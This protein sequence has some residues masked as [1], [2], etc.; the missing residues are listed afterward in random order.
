MLMY[1]SFSVDISIFYW[2]LDFKMHT[3][4][5]IRESMPRS[6]LFFLSVVDTYP[7][8]FKFLLVS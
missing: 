6:W 1:V 5:L 7:I 3:L 4:S 2:T 8:S